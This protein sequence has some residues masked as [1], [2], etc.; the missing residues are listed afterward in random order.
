MPFLDS[1]HYPWLKLYKRFPK[2]ASVDYLD[3]KY[4]NFCSH[5]VSVA[6]TLSNR[7]VITMYPYHS[8]LGSFFLGVMPLL[9]SGT[10][11]SEL[12]QIQKLGRGKQHITDASALSFLIIQP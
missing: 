7:G 2:D 11:K 10:F 4:I 1:G 3:V 12:S 6:L 5:H 8:V 9:W